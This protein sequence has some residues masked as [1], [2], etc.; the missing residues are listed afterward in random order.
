VGGELVYFTIDLYSGLC[1]YQKH[2]SRFPILG[3][4][5]KDYLA[6][7]AS[8]TDSERVFSLAGLIGTD[9]RNRLHA[10]NFEA[11]QILRSAYSSGFI[12]SKALIEE[13]IAPK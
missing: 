13:R 4:M 5:A 12:D 7:P 2:A 1:S 3:R 11:L 10:D 6:V 8:S 9:R